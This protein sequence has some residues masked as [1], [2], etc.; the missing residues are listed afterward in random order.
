MFGHLTPPTLD[1]LEALERAFPVSLPELTNGG[2]D[3]LV[4]VSCHVHRMH[5]Q[6]EVIQFL[7]NLAAQARGE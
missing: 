5:G 2:M 3:G 1:T 7:R 4:Q 6:Q